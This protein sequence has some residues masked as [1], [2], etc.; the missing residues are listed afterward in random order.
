MPQT[1]FVLGKA[2]AV[3][4][5]P[6]VV[7]NKVDRGDARPQEVLNEVF[8]LFAALD[9]TEEQLDFPALF[10]SAKEGW[11]SEEPDGPRENMAPLFDTVLRHVPPPVNVISAVPDNVVW[12][13]GADWGFSVDPTA[14][15]RFCIPDPTPKPTPYPVQT[16]A[17]DAE[18]A[19]PKPSPTPGRCLPRMPPRRA[20][21][22]RRWGRNLASAAADRCGC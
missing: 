2:L 11:A 21:A 18:I 9:A 13:Y 19:S 20:C 3:G 7:V 10:A 8:D 15:V 14:A 1:K 5:R 6:L 12:F 22:A 4:L 16:L 17:P